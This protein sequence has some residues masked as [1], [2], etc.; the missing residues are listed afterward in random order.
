[1]GVTR[2][3]TQIGRCHGVEKNVD[4]LRRRES[5]GNYINTDHDRTKTNWRMWN[6][7]TMWVA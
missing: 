7:Q 5:Q 3:L 6:I 4:K 1:M 2:R